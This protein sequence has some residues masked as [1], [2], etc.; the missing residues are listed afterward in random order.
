[1]EWLDQ[2]FLLRIWRRRDAQLLRLLTAR[3]LGMIRDHFD[4][5]QASSK[6]SGLS[7]ADFVR[8]IMKLLGNLAINEEEF[9]I[10]IL[11]LFANIDVSIWLVPYPLFRTVILGT[12]GCIKRN[13]VLS[14]YPPTLFGIYRFLSICTV[15]ILF[16]FF[17]PIPL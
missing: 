8:I 7:V 15:S 10:Q 13:G 1:M 9:C 11:E 12:K 3:N 16:L 2:D 17:Y 14:W 5:E 6:K 4:S